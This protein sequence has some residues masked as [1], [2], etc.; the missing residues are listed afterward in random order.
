MWIDLG[1][2][3]SIQLTTKR[4]SGSSPLSL[5]DVSPHNLWCKRF[6]SEDQ[7]ILRL[8][9]VSPSR[10]YNSFHD[11]FKELWKTRNYLWHTMKIIIVI[12]EVNVLTVIIV[13]TLNPFK[14]MTNTSPK[15]L[16]WT[17]DQRRL[18]D[19]RLVKR[20]ITPR[21]SIDNL[22][23]SSW[24]VDRRHLIWKMRKSNWSSPIQV[25]HLISGFMVL[26]NIFENMLIKMKEWE[27]LFS[28]FQCLQLKFILTRLYEDHN[29]REIWRPKTD[30][31]LIKDFSLQ[32]PKNIL[33]SCS[34]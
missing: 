5:W 26:P 17:I 29:P 9:L 2:V 30:Q 31:W 28:S 14:S 6:P 1:A 7:L 10:I 25:E 34:L 24:A 18:W 11:Q 12:N 3:C 33:M 4:T 15:Y 32:R 22:K 21:N 16:I 13:Y 27:I 8:S 20:F 23:R 19:H